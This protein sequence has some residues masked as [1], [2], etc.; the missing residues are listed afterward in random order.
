MSTSNNV[1]AMH[2]AYELQRL[3]FIVIEGQAKKSHLLEK[4][5]CLYSEKRL[6]HQP[7]IPHVTHNTLLLRRIKFW[8]TIKRLLEVESVKQSSNTAEQQDCEEHFLTH[9]ATII[10]KICS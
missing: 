5:Y 10:G 6:E 4:I 8:S 3:T 7:S 9:N 1:P 2:R